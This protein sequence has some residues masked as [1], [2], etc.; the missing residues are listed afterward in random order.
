MQSTVVLGDSVWIGNGL[1]DG[2]SGTKLESGLI[3]STNLINVYEN[4]NMPG[5][6]FTASPASPVFGLPISGPPQ[7]TLCF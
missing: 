7:E 5:T 2:I 6:Q 3:K 1:R 4:E